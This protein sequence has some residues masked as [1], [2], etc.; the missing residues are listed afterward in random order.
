MKIAIIS[1]TEHYKKNDGTIVGWGP[2]IKE[3]NNLLKI[4]DSIVHIA[5]LHKESAPDSA[6]SYT[7]DRIK[8]VSL[9]KSGGKGIEK[10]SILTRAPYNLVKIAKAIRDVDFVQF[11]APTGMG[12]YVLPFLKLFTN[13][14]YW[15]K[16]AGNWKDSQMPLGNKLQKLW[17]KT[18]VSLQTNITV[19]GQWKNERKNVIPFENPCLS[20]ADRNLGKE[21][22]E[23]KT[24][25]DK[26]IF[27]FVGALNSHK[28]VDQILESFSRL[29]EDRIGEIHFVGDGKEK[30]RYLELSKKIKNKTIFHGFLPKKEIN[31]IYSK[32]HFIVL[33]SKSEGFPKVIAEAMNFGCLPIVSDVSCIGQYIKNDV[34][35][36][37][38]SSPTSVILQ[39][40][41]LKSLNLSPVKYNKWICSNYNLAEKFTYEYYNE[42][43]I[44]EIFK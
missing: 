29:N 34:N 20:Q 38:L 19:N 32:S 4:A 3:I 41:I 39:K 8:F 9:K 11:R 31:R 15:V 30:E 36:F 44:T 21:L 27:C 1:H 33:P 7:S 24:Q 2:T 13:K 37:L 35:G 28:G 26:V 12:I 16:Y 23:K 10:L 14:K 40:N 18:C 42:R 6:L 17:L 25:G 43:L 22:V 5:P